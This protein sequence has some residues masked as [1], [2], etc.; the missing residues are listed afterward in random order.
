[1]W[2][3]VWAGWVFYL[4]SAKCNSCEWLCY[5]EKQMWFCGIV[6]FSSELFTIPNRK[7]RNLINRITEPTKKSSKDENRAKNPENVGKCGQNC[8]Q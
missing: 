3:E 8:G 5:A 1:M 6:G 4:L 2:A 7:I